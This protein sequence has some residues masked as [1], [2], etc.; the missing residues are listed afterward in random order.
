MIFTY[1]I[2]HRILKNLLRLAGPVLGPKMKLWV[3]LRELPLRK[4]LQLSN[5]YWFHASSGEVEYCKSMIWLVKQQHP[6]AQIVVTYSSPSAEKLFYNVADLVDQFIPLGWDEP[7]PVKELIDY[8]NPKILIFSKTDLWPELLHQV[9]KRNVR[10]GIISYNPRWGFIRDIFNNWLLSHLDFIACLDENVEKKLRS[11]GQTQNIFTAGDT[12]FDQVFF[13]LSQSSRLNL[14]CSSKLLVC[15]STWP[16][17]EQVL[18]E[19]L[20]A[21]KRKNIKIV[22]SPHET[23]VENIHRI[24]KEL[25]RLGLSFDLL[26]DLADPLQVNLE[27]DILIINK[28]GYLADAYRFADFAFVGGSFKE[29][30]HSVMEALC[31]GVP[32]ITGPYFTNNPEAVKYHKRFVFSTAT[33][34]EILR[35]IENLHSLSKN[36]I[37]TEMKKNLNASQN[38]LSR[39]D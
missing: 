32:V 11:Q 12:R 27:K 30:I 8:I 14:V 10:C 31:C 39:I 34:K 13:R 25:T 36:E 20:P 37:L 22:L 9:K 6:E 7:R 2:L 19:I 38:I 5:T 17:D 35:V 24:Q 16:Q 21:L 1:R 28:I 29:R 15:G 26:P 18:F 33:A 4:D 23:G 3:A